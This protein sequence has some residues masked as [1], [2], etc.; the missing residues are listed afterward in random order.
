MPP[1]PHDPPA[2][3]TPDEE[4]D[5]LALSN[6]VRDWIDETA[7]S[8]NDLLDKAGT[9]TLGIDAHSVSYLRRIVG[10]LN[11]ARTDLVSQ[12]PK[13]EEETAEPKE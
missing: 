7:S 2:D 4:T 9:P 5:P 1:H 6:E 8:A 11:E 10:L 3:G 13:D 12:L